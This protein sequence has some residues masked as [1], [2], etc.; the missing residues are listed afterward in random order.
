[1]SLKFGR[2]VMVLAAVMFSATAGENLLKDTNFSKESGWMVYIA[3]PCADSGSKSEFS[4][5]KAVVSVTATEKP[6][7]SNI[8]VNKNIDLEENTAYVLKC[9]IEST[10]AGK[11]TLAYTLTKAPYT[12]YCSK[13]IEIK[14]G[15][16]DI[17]VEFTPAG[18][19]GNYETPRTLRI[20]VAGLPGATLTFSDVTVEKK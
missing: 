1:M 7:V 14:E 8:Q 10:I 13:N 2:L 18:K 17:E 11:I 19:N 12:G 20:F 5:G 15:A 6:N 3:K 16:N 9:K 4:E